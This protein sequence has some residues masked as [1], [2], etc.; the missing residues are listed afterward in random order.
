VPGPFPCGGRPSAV[1]YLFL[2]V[3]VSSQEIGDGSA[4]LNSLGRS[5]DERDLEDA[6]WNSVKEI[7][8]RRQMT[9]SEL[10]GAI[11]AQRRPN[12]LSSA[13]FVLEFY[14]KYRTVHV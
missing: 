10:L 6:F 2:R 1:P 7:A 13:M 4:T 11:D 5:Q 3:G 8:H 14:R 9:L 12:N